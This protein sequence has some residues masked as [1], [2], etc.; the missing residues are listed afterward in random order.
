ME[1]ITYRGYIDQYGMV[2]CNRI[3]AKVAENT[4]N[5]LLFTAQAI[6]A[7]KMH[8]M[9][10][11]FDYEHLFNNSF[12]DGKLYR[13]PE[14]HPK[15][16]SHDNYTG[17]VL[18]SLLQNAVEPPK[19]LLKSLFKHFGVINGEILLRFPQIWLL[20]FCAVS[21]NF[22]KKL[23]F[24]FMYLLYLTQLPT[25][26]DDGGDIELKLTIVASLDIMYPE[27]SLFKK[28]QDRLTNPLYTYYQEYY[29]DN[30]PTAL[31]WK[32]GKE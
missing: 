9:P 29:G 27:L 11:S 23:L 5:G 10:M 19:K 25:K 32:Q 31:I 6:H 2:S 4:E 30:H 22:F 28:W 12:I 14:P 24:P 8:G 15:P 21:N 1:K 17:V 3:P 13:S 7:Q 26:E 18:G 16:E 20:L